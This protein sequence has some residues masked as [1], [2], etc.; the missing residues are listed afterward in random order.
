M[1]V[2]PLLKTARGQIDGILR[3]VEDDRYCVDIVNQVMATQSVLQKTIKVIMRSHV[4]HCVK[5]A[6]ESGC[7]EEKMEELLQTL[8]KLYR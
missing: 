8:D 6:L 4:E 3:M 1:Q 2:V 5:E 7:G